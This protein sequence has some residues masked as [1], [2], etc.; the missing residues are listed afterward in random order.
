VDL[1]NEAGKGFPY[2][3]GAGEEDLCF[4]W[5]LPG[6]NTV[7]KETLALNNKI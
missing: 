4:P 6:R 1:K 7:L 3:L 2:S 5:I